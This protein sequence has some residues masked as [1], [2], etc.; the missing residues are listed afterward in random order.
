MLR[1]SGCLFFLLCLSCQSHS[2]DTSLAKII[3]NQKITKDK[4][5]LK[6]DKSDYI[7]SVM[8]DEKKVLKTYPVVFGF[9]AVNDKLR[10]GDGCTPEGTFKVYSK[11]PHKSWSKFIWLD[12][13]TK[14]SWQKHNQA[15]KDG[16]IPK[17]ASIGGEIGIHG[18]P[19]G[20]DGMIALKENWTLGCI[21]LTNEAVNEIY[22]YLSKGTKVVIEP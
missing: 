12:Y 22:P 10:E 6:I 4:I 14:N 2:Q 8:A 20:T 13:P 3:D 16:K 19:K 21:S 15:K 9:D 11:Y 1:I 17:N 7:L 5:W 18:V